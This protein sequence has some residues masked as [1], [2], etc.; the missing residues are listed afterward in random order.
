MTAIKQPI[1]TSK[2]R[3]DFANPAWINAVSKILNMA[4]DRKTFFG[5]NG[6]TLQTSVNVDTAT[7]PSWTNIYTF[8]SAKGATVT[9]IVELANGEAMV[10]TTESGQANNLSHVYLSSGWSVNMATATWSEK[11]VTI[12][13]TITPAYCLYDWSNAKDGTVLVSESGAQTSGGAGN[14]ANDVARARRVWRSKDFGTTWT[15]IFDIVE[16]GASQGVPYGASLHMH[17]VAYD[18]DWG[19]IWLTYGDGSGDGDIIA[20]NGYAQ[21]VYSDNDG[22]TWQKMALPKLWSG[23]DALQFISV[24]VLNNSVIFTH[25]LSHPLT[26]LAFPKV[27]YRKLGEPVPG[28]TY[29]SAVGGIP[30]KAT[31]DARVPTF[32]AG[33]DFVTQTGTVRWC[34]AATEDDG[35]T[36]SGVY[37]EI[38]LQT[39]ALGHTGFEQVL[40]PTINGK[41][42]ATGRLYVN[43]DNTKT[44]MVA[45]LVQT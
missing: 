33:T 42:V 1:T 3:F 18:Q 39:P 34:V 12:G 26:P 44:T 25:D 30:R 41:V 31:S 16:Y 14:V 11:L 2:P 6:A 23:T 13:G 7:T 43:N 9:G 19:R 10:V 15:L 20:G 8:P 5:A 21:V 22:V 45:D 28:P 24:V 29:P 4:K 27:G 38:P 40:G 36:W 37:G 35:F 17:G 32:F